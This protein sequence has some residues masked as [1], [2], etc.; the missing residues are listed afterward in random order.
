MTY[1]DELI[2]KRN[3]VNAV[4]FWKLQVTSEEQQGLIE[5]IREQLNKYDFSNMGKAKRKEAYCSF[6]RELCLMYALW[7]NR[8]YGGGRDKWGKALDEFNIDQCYK[9]LIK[10]AII[11]E[12]RENKR[13]NIPLYHSTNDRLIDSVL[14]QGGLPMQLMKREE[15]SSAYEYYLSRLISYY[16]DLSQCDW[17]NI[18]IAQDLAESC[19]T[20]ETL[21][22]SEAVL[23][24]SMEIVKAYK[25]DNDSYFDNYEEIKSIIK[26]I[27]EGRGQKPKIES[28]KA[29]WAFNIE[30]ESLK[31]SYTIESPNQIPVLNNKADIIS[32][33][34]EG[35]LVGLYQRRG[36]IFNRMPGYSIR[37]CISWNSQ[38][39]SLILQRKSNNSF[40]N[41]EL[42]NSEPPFIEEPMILC[43]SSYGL[44][45]KS[46]RRLSGAPLSCLFPVN[47]ECEELRE[48][49]EL[50]FNGNTY[51]WKYIEQNKVQTLN[52]IE[53]Q[54]QEKIEL[55]CCPTDY[56]VSFFPQV[57]EWLEESSK[58][59][60]LYNRNNA[61]FRSLFKCYDSEGVVSNS[62]FKFFTKHKSNTDYQK[63]TGGSLPNGTIQMRVVYPDGQYKTFSLYN[64][65][66]LEYGIFDNNQFELKYI[67]G[68]YALL[69]DQSIEKIES[70][71]Y[72]IS[73][74]GNL[75][76]FTPVRFRL[77]SESNNNDYVDVGLKS[78][79][80]TSCFFDNKY[81]IPRQNFNI[82]INE[83]Y[84]YHLNVDDTA[85][86]IISFYEIAGNPMCVTRRKIRLSAGRYSLDILKD[87]IDRMFFING[88]N[89]YTKYASIK[90][91]GTEHE[92]RIRR[93]TYR[94]TEDDNNGIIVLRN[95]EE[96]SGL[97]LYGLAINAP[98]ESP[99]FQTTIELKESEAEK[100][101]YTVPEEDC[102]SEYIIFTD[103]SIS[104]EGMLPFFL[105]TKEHLDKDERN[106]IKRESIKTIH[107]ALVQGDPMEW[108]NVWFYMKTAIKYHLSYAH[109]FNTFHAIANDP[110][111]IAEFIIRLDVDKIGWDTNT[112]IGE[113]QRME[114]ELSFG[115]HYIP[116]KCWQKEFCRLENEYDSFEPSCQSIIGEKNNYCWNHFHYLEEI[117]KCQFDEDNVSIILPKLV[118]G[119]QMPNVPQY[120]I[121]YREQVN[122]AF[123]D[124]EK[125]QAPANLRFHKVEKEPQRPNWNNERSEIPLKFQYMAIVLPQCAAQ[126][127]HGADLELWSYQDDEQKNNVNQFIRRMIY[128]M[129]KYVP[130][131][132]N[133]LYYIALLREPIKQ[134]RKQN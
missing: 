63:Y 133:E 53:K 113:L 64:L 60:V 35:R 30:G 36:D 62:K 24:F 15:V 45:P 128:Y 97:S 50:K 81:N 51:Y 129:S 84:N 115:F 39:G 77:F 108:D 117:L 134:N 68:K 79:L 66:G 89:D 57:P 126:Y 112:I 123:S 18:N 56:S 3:I 65:N 118:I 1:I 121:D 26:K 20:N 28:F 59:V 10:D 69:A 25:D 102:L 43:E 85:T 67:G 21:R 41:V 16:E 8:C 48:C 105:N 82:S 49:H 95:K 101:H 106:R 87:D 110:Y 125:L 88:F 47:W 23:D 111:L 58:T 98:S 33:Y 91:Q 2:S 116:S 76:G 124:F 114:R 119:G 107:D 42:I 6:D 75:N 131:A 94:A 55:S 54:T 52:F 73:N 71:Y 4:P 37:G 130:E 27:K 92:L 103:N 96:V 32:Y 61:D 109:S 90:I 19:L 104:E 80:R 100:G 46:Q 40:T 70:G 5:Y 132:Y 12:L 7:W 11:I 14:A 34:L 122:N 99:I 22:K 44:E 78:P 17:R 29:L 9:D 83:L 127:V 120:T 31:L 38:N 72:Q 13:L 86:I 93:N 74:D